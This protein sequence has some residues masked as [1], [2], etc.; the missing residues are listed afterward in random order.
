MGFGMDED[1]DYFADVHDD[2]RRIESGQL[3][4]HEKML[5]WLDIEPSDFNEESQNEQSRCKFLW[6]KFGR[7]E[8]AKSRQQ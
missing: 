1:L 2:Q 3:T 7:K 8:Y 6:N 5:H 4:D